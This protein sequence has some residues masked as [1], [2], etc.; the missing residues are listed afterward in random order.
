MRY[1]NPRLLY[2]TLQDKNITLSLAEVKT[3]I[4]RF[5]YKEENLCLPAQGVQHFHVDRRLETFNMSGSCNMLSNY[6]QKKSHE[7]LIK[8]V[9]YQ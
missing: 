7:K 8:L 6:G 5:V 4:R 1:T 9:K 2:F 3:V